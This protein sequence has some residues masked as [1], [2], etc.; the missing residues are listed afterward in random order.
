MTDRYERTEVITIL[1]HEYTLKAPP[2]GEQTLLQAAEMLQQALATTKK[3]FPALVGDRLL[4]LTAM[5]VCSQL[6]EARQLHQQQLAQA[7]G[8][9]EATVESLARTLAKE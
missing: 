2:G 4:V 3:Q 6:I 9:V 5:N 1:D 7:Q 8:Q